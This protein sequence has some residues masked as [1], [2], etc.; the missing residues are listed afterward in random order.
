MSGISNYTPINLKVNTIEQDKAFQKK[1]VSVI[2]NLKNNDDLD[3]IYLKY[4]LDKNL[5]NSYLFLEE[6]SLC[7]IPKDGYY[8]GCTFTVHDKTFYTN[9]M[10]KYNEKGL[11]SIYDVS[12]VKVVIITKKLD[13]KLVNTYTIKTPDYRIVSAYQ[14]TIIPGNNKISKQNIDIYI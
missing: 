10:A 11:E 9:F 8:M 3:A 4:L 6:V 1:F 12:P 2:D 14:K 13:Y 5:Y 7:T